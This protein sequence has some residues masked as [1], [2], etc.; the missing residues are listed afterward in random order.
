MAGVNLLLGIPVAV[1]FFY[2]NLLLKARQR[3][4]FLLL[5]RSQ[6]MRAV[7]ILLV[8][9]LVAGVANG[10]K[11]QEPQVQSATESFRALLLVVLI[12]LDLNYLV[13]FAAAN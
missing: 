13:S 3:N 10:L 11:V 2:F 4:H 8:V 12:A 6:A 5:R 7:I 1:T 9:S